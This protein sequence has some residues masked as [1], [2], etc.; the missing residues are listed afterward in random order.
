MKKIHYLK[1]KEKESIQHFLK[2]I[3]IIKAIS[4]QVG[5]K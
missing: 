5:S 1:Y 3:K 2:E 4:N